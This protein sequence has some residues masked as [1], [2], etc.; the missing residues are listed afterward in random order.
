[1][2]TESGHQRP[3]VTFSRLIGLLLVL[4]LCTPAAWA[5]ESGMLSITAEGVTA[6]RAIFAQHPDQKVRN[7][8]YLAMKLVAPEY[9]HYS[10]MKPDFETGMLV[11]RT[12]RITTNFYVNARTKHMDALLM[13]AAENGAVQVVNLGAGYDSRAYRFRE[14][15][16]TV[17]FF[18]I[19]L[20]AMIEEKKR[21]LAEALGKVPDYVAYV[22]IDFNIQ[23]IPD[24]LRKAGYDPSRKTFFIWEG[25]TYYISAE[26]VDSTLRFIATQSATGSSV[27]FDYMPLGVIQGDFKRYPDA[28][29]LSFW[30]AYRGEPFVFG[31]PEGDSAT[32]V[33]K[34]GLK[35]MSDLHPKDLENRYLT[36]SDGTLDGPCC[37]AFRIMHAVVPSMHPSGVD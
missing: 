9:W 13:Q 27:V 18:E 22:P 37:S 26:A 33:S 3:I 28:R 12:Y 29:A 2:Q 20:P 24:E 25:V 35:V 6:A 14:T 30:V 10:L 1:M 36:R 4:T 7:D 16:P 34:R 21:R 31:I 23:N 15:M 11:T 19:D 17:R 32:Y 5:V 8:D